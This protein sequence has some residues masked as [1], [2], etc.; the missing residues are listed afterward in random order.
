[1]ISTAFKVPGE[2][3]TKD[4]HLIP[5]DPTW[6]N[7]PDAFDFFPVSHWFRNSFVIA[8]LTTIGKLL[9]A[10]PAAFAFARLRFRGEKLLFGLVLGTMVVPF[11][12]TVVPAYVLISDLHWVNTYQGV[13]VPSIAHCAF[14]VF[15]LRQY[16]QTL[17][18]EILDAAK[19][20]GATSWQML[21]QI[22][23]P[24]VR[25]AVA[26]VA[27]LSFLGGWNQYL[28]PL[29]VLNDLESK[30]LAVGMQ[31]FSANSDSS[32]LWGPMMATAALATLP[33]LVI[34]AIAQKHIISTFVTSGVKG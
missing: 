10:V 32:Q 17:P 22:V 7:F 26:V 19:V 15:L 27:I 12:V 21:G 8:S 20:D 16:M 24:N 13:I 11:A 31:F 23:L 18:Q 30:T 2:V 34:Y 1:M 25:P 3:F 5:T 29:L 6:R 33:P 4:L 9:V 28:W 14:A